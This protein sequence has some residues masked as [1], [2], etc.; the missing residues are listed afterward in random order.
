MGV[1]WVFMPLS[2]IYDILGV[3]KCVCVWWGGGGVGRVG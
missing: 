3:K 1:T 2:V